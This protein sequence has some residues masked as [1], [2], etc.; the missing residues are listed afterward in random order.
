MVNADQTQIAVAQ[1]VSEVSLQETINRSILGGRRGLYEFMQTVREIGNDYVQHELQGRKKQLQVIAELYALWATL[2]LSENSEAFTVLKELAIAKHEVKFLN[3]PDGATVVLR[4]A[5]SEI[6]HT[7]VSKIGRVMRYCLDNKVTYEKFVNYVELNG[8]LEGIRAKAVKQDQEAAKADAAA[9]GQTA[10]VTSAISKTVSDKCL[11][12]LKTEETV[13]ELDS[14]KWLETE[15]F[16]VMIAVREGNN[17]T[18]ELKDVYMSEEQTAQVLKL[19]LKQKQESEGVEVIKLEKKAAELE[20]DSKLAKSGSIAARKQGDM[21]TMR[22]LLNEAARLDGQAI[23]L[24]LDLKEM[25]KA[26]A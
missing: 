5:F 14:T 2:K 23:D 13:D 8:G 15:T 25:R 9:A 11:D 20:F 4:Y 22:E 3:E 1:I 7:Q 6:S 19:Y 16:R 12:G 21:Q 17:A 26:V 24:R 18:A 10:T